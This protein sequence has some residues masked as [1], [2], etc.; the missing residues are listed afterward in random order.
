EHP[1]GPA[2]GV[3]V[4]RVSQ[5]DPPLLSGRSGRNRGGA[6]RRGRA[7]QGEGLMP[8]RLLAGAM[9]AVLLAWQ[10][11]AAQEGGT[12]AERRAAARKQQAELRE[13]IA[14]LQNDLEAGDAARRD[15]ASALK[16]SES[17]I[18]TLNRELSELQQQE[19]DVQADLQAI[20]AD[21]ERQTAALAQ[22][23]QE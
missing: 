12:L 10:P 3:R 11:V 6:G 21:T 7:G 9:V 20:Q 19:K 23:R 15:A 4:G 8:M 18:S 22:R 14:I 16:A 1:H 13:R 2:A 5:A 17:A